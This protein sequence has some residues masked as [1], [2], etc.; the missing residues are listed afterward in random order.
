MAMTKNF[1]FMDDI[2]FGEKKKET[3]AVKQE[4]KP[5]KADIKAAPEPLKPAEDIKV[6]DKFDFPTKEKEIKRVHKNFLIS[7]AMNAKFVALAKRTGNS[8]N[9]LFNEILRQVFE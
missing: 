6:S 8:E 5:I 1:N 4:E 9:E 2:E 3:V 7:E